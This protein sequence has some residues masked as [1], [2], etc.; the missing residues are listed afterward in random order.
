MEVKKGYLVKLHDGSSDFIEW[1]D[2]NPG[3]TESGIVPNKV[4]NFLKKGKPQKLSFTQL[5]QYFI[6]L[7]AILGEIALFN[8]ILNKEEVFGSIFTYLIINSVLGCLYW[9][10][11]KFV[12]TDDPVRS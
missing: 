7:I 1:S 12:L 10:F 2:V 3:E 6:G 9:M 4:L 11:H 8:A 5:L